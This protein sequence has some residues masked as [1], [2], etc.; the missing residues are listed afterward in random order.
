MIKKWFKNRLI[1]IMQ[2][3]N[4]APWWLTEEECTKHDKWTPCDLIAREYLNNGGGSSKGFL[5]ITRA[6][7]I[8]CYDYMCENKEEL[9]KLGY[10]SGSAW[11]NSG[12]LLWNNYNFD[13]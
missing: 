5:G 12:V 10:I 2:H 13:R 4:Y 8:K 7:C 11:N 3:N 9:I 6:D 1:T